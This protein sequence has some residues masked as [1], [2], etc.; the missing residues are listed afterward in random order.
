MIS[1][2]ELDC[3]PGNTRPGNLIGGVIEGTG[4]PIQEPVSKCF[5]NWTWEY[6]VEPEKWKE[7]ATTI[8]ERITALHKKGLIRYG[9]WTE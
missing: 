9:S 7:I 1:I 3:Q 8:K 2:I 5:G 6:E 4:L